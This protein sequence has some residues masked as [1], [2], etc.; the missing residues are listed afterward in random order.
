MIRTYDQI[1][2][3]LTIT[4][5]VSQIQGPAHI[6]CREMGVLP[7]GPNVEDIGGR[8]MGWDIIDHTRRTLTTRAPDAGPS[9]SNPVPVG[10]KQATAIRIYDEMPLDGARL[11]RRR[12]LGQPLGT[13]DISGM[14]YIRAQIRKHS[15]MGMNTRELMCALMLRDG[16]FAILRNG[17]EAQI[18]PLGTA[19]ASFEVTVGHPAQNRGTCEGVF[20]GGWATASTAPVIKELL[21]LN[22]HTAQNARFTMRKAFVRSATLNKILEADVVA[23]TGGTANTVFNSLAFAGETSNPEGNLASNLRVVL[24]GMPTIEWIT[25]DERVTLADGTSQDFLKEG[26]VLFT[27]GVN[28]GWVGWQNGSEEVAIRPYSEQTEEVFGMRMWMQRKT[29]PTVVTVL[30]YLDNGMLAPYAP[31]SWYLAQVYATP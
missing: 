17:D 7:D 4:K 31:G 2:H 11:F 18:F 21:D 10:H 1:F 15:Q 3:H 26:Q 12:G 8:Q 27:P 19:G 13:V 9:R 5:I 20:N 24:R 25:Y 6:L 30:K 23:K 14:R 16:G 29:D 28:D 22:D